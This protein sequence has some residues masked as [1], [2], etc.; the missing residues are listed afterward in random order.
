MSQYTP[1]NATIV[2]IIET[3]LQTYGDPKTRQDQQSNYRFHGKRDSY[4]QNST[5]YHLILP[6]QGWKEKPNQ[7]KKKGKFLFFRKH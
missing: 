3:K 6:T 7:T 2:G 4:L 1:M 5:C